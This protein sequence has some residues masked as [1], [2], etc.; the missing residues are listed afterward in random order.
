[1]SPI[2]HSMW[3]MGP[4]PSSSSL[5]LVFPTTTD[6]PI[7]LNSA[8]LRSASFIRCALGIERSEPAGLVQRSRLVSGSRL[9]R[10]RPRASLD[11]LRV[12]LSQ[13]PDSV[14]QTNGFRLPRIYRQRSGG[15][16]STG[17]T[18]PQ[19]GKTRADLSPGTFCFELHL[20][21]KL[22]S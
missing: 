12:H 6:R 17:A 16:A 8:Y 4:W 15:S 19:R 21:Q 22:V 14:G 10:A 3:R 7:A 13:R 9:R 18:R 5:L 2:K 11:R 1:M 20:V